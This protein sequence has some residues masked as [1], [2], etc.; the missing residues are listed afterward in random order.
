MTGMALPAAT[1][2]SEANGLS[3]VLSFILR[4]TG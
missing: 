4:L 1:L 2:P 3:G